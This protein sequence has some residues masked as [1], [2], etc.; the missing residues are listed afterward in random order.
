MLLLFRI[1][2][3]MTK[4]LLGACIPNEIMVQASAPG[5]ACVA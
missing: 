5:S 4:C 3:Q 1:P 2:I